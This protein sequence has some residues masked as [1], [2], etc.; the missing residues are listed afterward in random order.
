MLRTFVTALVLA[1]CA[2]AAEKP[3]PPPGV[4][5]PANDRDD[6]EVG[7]RKLS[8]S[9]DKLKANLLVND[10]II[11]RDAVH[12]ALKY[13]EFFR[14]EEIGRA[15]ELLK[16]GQERADALSRGDAPWTTA[17]GLVV[18]GYRSRIDDS[19]QPYGLVVPAT[20]SPKAPRKWRMDAWFHGRGETL[21]EVN[22]LWERT[23]RPG[24]F[25]PVDTIMLHLYGRYCNANKFAGEVDFFEAMADVKKHY[26]ID[27]NRIAVRGFSMGGASTWQ[28]AT[29]YPGHW[30]VAAPGA[31]FSETR[32]FLGNFRNDPIRPAWWEE[33]LWRMYDATEYALNFFNLPLVAYSGEIDRQKQAADIMARFLE[34]EGITNMTHIIGPKTP[35]RYHPDSKVEIDRRLDAIMERGRDP[36]PR[37]IKFV[38]FTTAYNRVKWLVVDQLEQHWER[39]QV[40]AEVAGERAVKVATKNVSALTFDFGPGGSPLAVDGKIGINIDGETVP[41][42]APNTDRSWRVHFAKVN[43]KWTT[44]AAAP[45]YGKAKRH[46]SQGPIDDAFMSRFIFVV[47]SGEASQKGIAERIAAEQARAIT[48]WRRHFRGEPIVKKDSEITDADISDANLVM[49]GDPSSNRM[50]AR[51]M[52]KLPVRWTGDSVTLGTKKFSAATN[53]PV[54][55][56]P[57]PLNPRRYVVVNSG[58]TFREYDY[59]NNARQ[60]P[61]LPDWAVV[62]VTVPADGRFP[63]KIADAGFFG[64][65]WELK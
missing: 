16:Q 26:R 41:A 39:A 38:T 37:T 50:M 11:F 6:L 63:G 13:N 59:L 49:W 25:T 40:I 10:V 60:I 21:S 8:D 3:I 36:Y 62:D 35:H 64:E 24:E 56:Y 65:K 53:Y 20:W 1:L 7:L 4:A 45:E 19:V 9:I 48:E 58:F 57:N 23:T 52:D 29:H 47:P 51:V 27:E 12:F 22:F 2:A 32:E 31:G 46:H 5:V 44:A 33:K 34:K 54:L 30:A 42:T 15:K 43:G 28:F 61:K 55:I 14:A 18:R 17:T